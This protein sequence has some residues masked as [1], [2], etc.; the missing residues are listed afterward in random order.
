MNII[1]TYVLYKII[2]KLSTPF[3][4]WKMFADGVIDS[5]GNFFQ[6]KPDRTPEQMGYSY[7]DVFCL[8]IKRMMGKIPGGSTRIATYAAALWLLREPAAD[9]RYT[10]EQIEAEA[11]KFDLAEQI[12]VAES[13][14]VEDGEG[15]AVPAN[16]VGDGKIADKKQG[17]KYKTLRRKL[18]AGLDPKK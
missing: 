18:V 4:K 8:N 5:E 12:A 14:I 7:L 15:S 16:N 1:D 2:R 9:K 17:L 13:M 3:E 10:M 6:H 11:S